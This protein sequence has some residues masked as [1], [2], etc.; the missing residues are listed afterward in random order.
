M[1]QEP[2]LLGERL[3]AV[4]ALEGLLAGVKPTVSLQMR[5]PAEGLTTVW[6]F[7]RPVPAVDCLVR[8]QVGG[9]ME[10]LSAGATSELPLL[11]V[12][13]QVKAQVS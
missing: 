3:V 9:L 11:V 8:H 5:C 12:G 10:V 4:G 6:T 2:C 7:K 13:G 1:C